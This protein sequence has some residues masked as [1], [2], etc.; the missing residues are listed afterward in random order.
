MIRQQIKA[1]KI[2]DRVGAAG[3]Q[4]IFEVI[5]VTTGPVP[6]AK[7]RLVGNPAFIMDVPWGALKLL[8][9]E[10]ATKQA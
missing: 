9:P 2:G 1:P 4:G 7:L 5:A 8:G 6:M 3:Q 10:S